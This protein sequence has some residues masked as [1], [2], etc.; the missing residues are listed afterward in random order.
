VIHLVYITSNQH[1]RAEFDT[2]QMLALSNGRRVADQ[3]KV[4]IREVSIKETLNIDIKEMVRQEVM[5]AYQQVLTP[6]FVEHAGLI[7]D[8]RSAQH[9]PGGLT[10]PMWNALGA[11]FL[12]ETGSASKP[13]TARAVVA[14]CDGMSV[15]TFVGETHGALSE[16]PRGSSAFYWDTIFIPDGSNQTYAELIDNR[17][18]QH[19]VREFSQSAKALKEMFEY[20]CSV[21][22]P[23]LWERT[24]FGNM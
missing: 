23:P 5:D 19:K 14:Y 21:S 6:C 16:K 24:P 7:F 8:H 15:T 10:K 18:L 22:R 20:L 13:V 9:Y 12:D 2:I 4:E 1:K 17:G 3:F 11:D